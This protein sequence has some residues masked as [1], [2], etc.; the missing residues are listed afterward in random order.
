MS[1]AVASVRRPTSSLKNEDIIHSGRT[2]LIPTHSSCFRLTKL[3]PTNPG[4]RV[5]SADA[6]GDLQILED[7]KGG[8]V[9]V[10]NL[11]TTRFG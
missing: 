9:V 3:F 8:P 10:G 4:A 5:Q 6:V 11:L 1:L 7:K 2:D